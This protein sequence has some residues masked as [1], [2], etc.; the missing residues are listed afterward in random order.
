MADPRRC[1]LCGRMYTAGLTLVTRRDGTRF[2]VHQPLT[3]PQIVAVKG[4]GR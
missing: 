2:C 3:T 4:A 1:Q